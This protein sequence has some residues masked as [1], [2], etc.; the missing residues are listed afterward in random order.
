MSQTSENYAKAVDVIMAGEKQIVLPVK[1]LSSR[2]I[3][4]TKAY[5]LDAGYDL[6]APVPTQFKPGQI[7][8][9]DT[10][11]AVAIPDG[12]VGLLWDRS[13]MGAKGIKVLGGVIDSGYR[14]PL[15]INL[16]LTN[17]NERDWIDFPAGHKI[18]QLVVQRVAHFPVQEFINNLPESVRGERGF[19]SSD[20]K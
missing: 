15:I 11:I 14:G 5:P 10:E 19:G 1:R 2:A 6:Y 8:K 9:V 4:P 7:T 17:T 13:S 20:V 16:V 12:Y 3:L 18:A